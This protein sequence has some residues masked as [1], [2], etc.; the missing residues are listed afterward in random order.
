MIENQTYYVARN[1][2]CVCMYFEKT[3]Q[4]RFLE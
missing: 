4:I 2:G 3:R 1:D